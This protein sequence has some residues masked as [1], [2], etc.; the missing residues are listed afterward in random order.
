MHVFAIPYG[1]IFFLAKRGSLGN[2]G[3]HSRKGTLLKRYVQK[4]NVVDANVHSILT[5]QNPSYSSESM[6]IGARTMPH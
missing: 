3:G 2:R 5:R 6:A 1:W 4:H